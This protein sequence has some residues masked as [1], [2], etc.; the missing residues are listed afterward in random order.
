MMD[1]G[2]AHFRGT[3][4]FELIALLGRGATGAVYEAFD[5]EQGT[6]LALKVLAHRNP[7]EVSY[8]K[9]EFRALQG[10]RHRNLIELRE[11]VFDEGHWLLTM[12]LVRG[13]DIVAYARGTNVRATG[14]KIAALAEASPADETLRP[15]QARESLSSAG[16]D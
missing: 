6:R 10:I 4:R 15:S 12:D 16:E 9:N 11:L 3:Q 2:Q 8:F 13:V 5:C 14:T 1:S 7:E